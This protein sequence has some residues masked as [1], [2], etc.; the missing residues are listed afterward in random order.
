M[1]RSLCTDFSARSKADLNKIDINIIWFSQIFNCWIHPSRIPI[2]LLSL[3]PLFSIICGHP[4]PREPL[5]LAGMPLTGV[6]SAPQSSLAPVAGAGILH[7]HYTSATLITTCSRAVILHLTVT[8]TAPPLRGLAGFL[9]WAATQHP[10]NKW[11][12][13]WKEQAA[14]T[15]Y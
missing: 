5:S 14:R 12:C 11:R 3:F 1:S 13:C 2:T 10:V 15:N 4:E 7:P 9:S 6:P 8:M